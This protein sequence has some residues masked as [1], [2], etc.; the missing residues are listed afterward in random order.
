MIFFLLKNSDI[1]DCA[2]NPCSHGTC[3]DE[4]NDFTCNCDSGW[5][6]KQCDKGMMS[7]NNHLIQNDSQIHITLLL[8]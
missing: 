4:L 6:G 5:E 1:D 3:Q 8:L 2:V 7:L